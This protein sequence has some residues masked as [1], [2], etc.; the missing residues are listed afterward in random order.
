[1]AKTHNGGSRQRP[2]KK[3]PNRLNASKGEPPYGKGKKP[4]GRY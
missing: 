3:T 2:S 4:H 1:M